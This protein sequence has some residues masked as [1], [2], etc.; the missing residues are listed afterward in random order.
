MVSQCSGELCGG[1]VLSCLRFK[2]GEVRAEECR[3][4]LFHFVKAEVSGRG[5]RYNKHG[6]GV[7]VPVLVAVRVH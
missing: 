7:A 1:K 4:E 6:S 5:G 2:M 3:N